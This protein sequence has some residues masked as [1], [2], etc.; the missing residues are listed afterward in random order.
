MEASLKCNS[1]LHE[2]WRISREEVSDSL[3]R[4]RNIGLQTLVCMV[5]SFLFGVLLAEV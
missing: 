1:V 4:A 5:C 3:V 2:V